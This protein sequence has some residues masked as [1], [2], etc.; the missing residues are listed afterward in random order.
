[1]ELIQ[2]S[3][4]YYVPSENEVFIETNDCDYDPLVYIISKSFY[5]ENK[6]KIEKLDT[7]KRNIPYRKID[8]APYHWSFVRDISVAEFE[9]TCEIEE[10]EK[11]LTNFKNN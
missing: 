6:E 11:Y 9:L 3:E 1:M 2:K 10:M 4:D 7:F 8:D 5:K